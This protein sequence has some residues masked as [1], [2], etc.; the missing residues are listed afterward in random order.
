M[1]YS[2]ISEGNYGDRCPWRAY[3]G[4]VDESQL[5]KESRRQIREIQR[6]H[7][8]DVAISAVDVLCTGLKVI[9]PAI[10]NS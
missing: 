9:R 7:R 4:R 6:L 3:V 5:M 2:Y 10:P 1:S 8:V